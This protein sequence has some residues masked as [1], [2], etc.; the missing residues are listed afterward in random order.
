MAEPEAVQPITNRGAVNPDIVR[1]FKF[2]A[3]LVQRQVSLFRQSATNPVLK[4]LQ[5]A[6]PVLIALK[7]WS[8]A[9]RLPAQ[10]HHVIHEAWRNPKMSGR[11]AATVTLIDETDNALAQLNWMWLAHR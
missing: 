3:K 9:A 2:Q 7:L 10:F 4:P 6:T 8:K 5:L 11:F 1:L